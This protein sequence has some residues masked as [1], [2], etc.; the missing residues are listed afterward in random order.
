M[1]AMIYHIKDTLVPAKALPNDRKTQYVAVIGPEEWIEMNSGFDM[2]I[3]LDMDMNDIHGTRAEPNFDSL[4]GTFSIPRRDDISAPDIKFA[5]ALD[6]KG[7]VFI[8]STGEAEKITEVIR[9]TK[10]WKK[11][12]LERFIYDFLE[13]IIH[14]D[15][16]LLER[17]EQELDR[18]EDDIM[19]DTS[20]E[21]PIRINDIRSDVRDLR[22][23]YEQ[24]TDLAQELEENE[25][26]FF[27]ANNLRYFHLV[28][29]RIAALHDIASSL[30]DYSIQVRDLYQ[31]RLDVRQNRIMTVLTIVTTLFM[32]LTL[33][34]GWYGM[35]FVYMPELGSRFGY[36]AVI[37]LSILTVVISIAIF[38]KKKWL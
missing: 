17:Y 8:D 15:Q 10:R 23:H 31:S 3:E 32:P 13:H 26:N 35:N 21:Y 34:A 22:I 33:I 7:I 4:T 25:N 11:P 5:F 28:I 18:I 30:R 27:K 16:Q 24:L 12:S 38:K 14:G 9:T 2:G 1:I 37:I 6:E 19:A 20:D 36:P 29:Q